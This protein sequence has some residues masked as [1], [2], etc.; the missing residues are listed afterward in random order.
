MRGGKMQTREIEEK[1]MQEQADKKQREWLD[2]EGFNA[3]GN[4]Y[5]VTG[6][7]YSIRNELKEA[8]F[9]FNPTLLW[10]SAQ[11][12]EE[13][14]DRLVEVNW[15]QLLEFSAWGE[16]HY[17]KETSQKI[18]EL[19]SDETAEDFTD[20]EWLEGDKF[21]DLCV[22]LVRRNGFE[23]KF[24]WTNIYTFQTEDKN[25]LTWFSTTEQTIQAGDSCFLSGKIKDRTEYKG[26]KQTVVT[27]CKVK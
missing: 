4:T 20:S 19:V 27:R 8:G 5:I 23:G 13:Y 14:A 7:T 1:K 15:E 12:I 24:G 10:H 3:E 17:F 16:G 2:K 18:K 22:T 26:I 21:E 25:I 6:E 9:R 11:I